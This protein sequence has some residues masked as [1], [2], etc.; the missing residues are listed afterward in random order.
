MNNA[1]CDDILCCF[2]HLYIIL[3]LGMAESSAGGPLMFGVVL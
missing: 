3:S 2:M 1:T